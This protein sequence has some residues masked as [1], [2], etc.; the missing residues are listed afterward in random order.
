MPSGF[1]RE[2][3][4]KGYYVR[5]VT[6][7]R[8]QGLCG[9]SAY[10]GV[11]SSYMDVFHRTHATHLLRLD[12]D[13]IINRADKLHQA[14]ADNVCAGAWTATVHNFYGC[15]CILSRRLIEGIISHLNQFNGIPGQSNSVL[16]E[17]R[18]TGEMAQALNLGEVRLWPYVREGG[19]GAGWQYHK[20]NSDLREYHRR[21]DV[22]TFGNRYLLPGTDCEARDQVGITMLDYVR[23]ILPTCPNA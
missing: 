10:R 9:I 6:F 15:C 7:N 18:A 11:L 22:I 23:N 13:T 4:A 12:S 20:A 3:I 19:F 21:Y 14:V 8:D 17:D 2:M 16:V 1:R 5:A